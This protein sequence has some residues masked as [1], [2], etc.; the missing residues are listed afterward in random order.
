NDLFRPSVTDCFNAILRKGMDPI[1]KTQIIE[2]FLNI[3]H[4]KKTL[5]DIFISPH[6]YSSEFIEKISHL[7]NTIGIELIEAFKKMKSKNNAQN[8]LVPNDLQALTLISNA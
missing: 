4:I 1:A 7:F 5:S 8:G 3:E 6:L 2:N